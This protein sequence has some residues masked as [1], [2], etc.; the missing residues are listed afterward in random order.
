MVEQDSRE[1]KLDPWLKENLVCPRDRDLLEERPGELRCPHNHRYPIVKGVPVMLVEDAPATHPVCGESIRKAAGEEDDGLEELSQPTEGV[2]SYVQKIIVGTHGNMYR[3]LQGR[4]TSYPIPD[5]P[6]ERSSGELLLDIGCNWGRWCIAAAKKGYEPVGIDPSLE[7]IMAARRVARQ[8]GIDQI[9]YVVGDGRHLP[10]RSGIFDVVFSYGVLQHFSKEDVR[11]SLEDVRRVLGSAGR[12]LIQ[13]PNK[14][15]LRCIYSQLM[16]LRNRHIF[17]VRYWN[18]KELES[19]FAET[20]GP[21]RL[22]VDGFLTLNPQSS[23]IDILPL[24]YQLV[25]RSSMLLK[26]IS[27]KITPL[28]YVADSLYVLVPADR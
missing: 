18:P 13:M 8:M 16:N 23:D 26:R 15:G 27:G 19:L 3:H 6:L 17:R 4:L 11:R 28:R 1:T 20:I 24:R 25:V 22:F 2:D 7:G 21:G 10:F 12:V 14:F 5:I 9:R